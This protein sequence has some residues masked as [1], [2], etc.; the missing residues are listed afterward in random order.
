MRRSRELL[1]SFSLNMFAGCQHSPQSSHPQ[2]FGLR[3]LPR[4]SI[5]S[6]SVEDGGHTMTS[7]P[8]STRWIIVMHEDDSAEE[9]TV[10]VGPWK[11]AVSPKLHI[12]FRPSGTLKGAT[13]SPPLPGPKH[14][15]ATS[16][17][18][19]QP[20]W[21]MV[22]TQ[23]PPTAPSIWTIRGAGHSSVNKR[24]ENESLCISGPTAAV[25]AWELVGGGGLW[26]V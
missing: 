2:V 9:S 19:W 17:L 15:R 16:L 12:L 25:S 18:T 8:C 26:W 5:T 22:A 24:V 3:M 10:L 13:S 4:S 21:D 23:Q 1:E 11:K 6:G 7:S 14:D 20:C